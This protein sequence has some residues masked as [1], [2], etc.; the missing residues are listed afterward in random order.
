MM[1]TYDRPAYD[2][3]HQDLREAIQRF[4]RAGELMRVR[5]ADCKLEMGTLA[6]IVYREPT[7]PAILFEDIPGYPKGF[8]AISGATNSARRLAL[9][10]G[11]PEPRHP[12]DV[13]RAYRDR[14]KV[15]KPIP[16]RTV[17]RDDEVVG[18]DV[19]PAIVLVE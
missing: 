9:L 6:E 14:M 2:Q 11:F 12:L 16:P 4:E 7:P 1:M 17:A 18:P 5:G 8:R 13:V 10:L 3:P 15:H 19:A